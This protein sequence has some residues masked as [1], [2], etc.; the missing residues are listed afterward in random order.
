MAIE[1]L[2]EMKLLGLVIRNDLSWK[3]NTEQMTKKAYKRLWIIRR[4]IRNGATKEDLIDVYIKQVRSVL[5]YGVPVWN[6]NLTQGDAKN[7][8]RVQK[9]FL[10][11]LLGTQ[12]DNYEHALQ[13]TQLESLATRRTA[14][15]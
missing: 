3:S 4:L 1:T 15:C 6:P 9:C 8:E 10:H 13:I 12:Y 5:E 11:M 7:I 14:L 2:E